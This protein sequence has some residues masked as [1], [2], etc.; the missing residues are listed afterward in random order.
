M[1][2]ELPEAGVSIILST[3]YMLVVP[4][5]QPIY[6]Q[7]KIP[8]FPPP[9]SYI[10]YILRPLL[11]D[12]WP[13][14]ASIQTQ[15]FKISPHEIVTRSTQPNQHEVEEFAQD[16]EEE[17]E[18]EEQEEQ[19]QLEEPQE[20]QQQGAEGAEGNE[21]L[22]EG[23]VEGQEGGENINGENYN[24]EQNQQGDMPADQS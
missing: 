18:Q 21:Q 8:V 14:T 9:M 20:G 22:G 7:N 10:G 1:K 3:R 11:T 19:I 17:E 24:P 13:Q 4:L 15:E 6:I 5:I 16:E 2:L 23:I 12:I